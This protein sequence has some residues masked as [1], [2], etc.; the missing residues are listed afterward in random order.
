MKIEG[1]MKD[2]E[3]ILRRSG[4]DGFFD[5]VTLIFNEGDIVVKMKEKSDLGALVG[6]FE[7]LDVEVDDGEELV[8]DTQKLLDHLSVIPTKEDFT[9]TKEE[10]TLKIETEN[11]TV[12]FRLQGKWD[13]LSESQETIPIRTEDG[14]KYFSNTKLT[15]EVKTSASELSRIIKRM[16]VVDVE[17]VKMFIKDG[18]FKTMVGDLTEE[19]LNPHEFTPKAEVVDCEDEEETEIGFGLKEISSVLADDIEFHYADD[20]PLVVFDEGENYRTVYVLT[21]ME[22]TD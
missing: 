4:C 9:A 2:F 1:K 7:S 3:D 14:D 10:G 8:I 20:A 22:R 11:E 6:R 21:P 13:S 12:N 15:A 18:Q 19:K 17:F 16:S 5:P